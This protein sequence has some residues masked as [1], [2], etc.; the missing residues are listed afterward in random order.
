MKKIELLAPAGSFAALKAAVNAG[1][2]AVYIGGSMFGARAYADNP[3]QDDLIAAIDYCHL[4]G[5]K[6]YLTVNTLFKENELLGMLENY[7]RPYYSAGLDGVI[8][9]D[10]GAMRYISEHF[11]G[12]PIHVSTQAS[13]TAAEGINR[14]MERMPA[15]TRVVPARELSIE[16][17]RNLREHTDAQIEVFIHGALCYSYS[18]QCLLS[19]MIGGRSGNRGRCAQ[20]C[21][22]L[23]DGR[24]LL[25]PKDNCQVFAIDELIEAGVDSF[26]IEGRMKSPEYT[27]G[28]V[29]VYRRLIDLY[30]QY[31]PEGYRRYL[32]E[33]KKMVECEL[34]ELRE[35]YNRGGFNHGY[36][37]Q[38]NGPDMMAFD[39]PN[40]SG[41]Q[42]GEV[43]KTR[44]REAVIRFDRMVNA[45][46]V[47]EIRENQSPV[48]EFTLG[49]GYDSGETFS[50]I[51]MKNRRAEAGMPVYRTRNAELLQTIDT[52]YIEQETKVPVKGC[53]CAHVGDN[54]VLK[55][56]VGGV[57]TM[58]R[59]S[60]PLERATG[61]PMDTA[62]VARQLNKLG[63]TDFIFESLDID[64]DDDVFLV[65]GELNRMRRE[66]IAEL[67]AL[68][69]DTFRRRDDGTQEA[70]YDSECSIGAEAQ[71]RAEGKA[72]AEALFHAE[73]EAEAGIQSHAEGEAEVQTFYDGV[74]VNPK[75]LFSVWKP[76]QLKRLKNIMPDCRVIFNIHSTDITQIEPLLDR[77][78]IIGLPYISRAE[79]LAKVEKF[80]LEIRAKCPGITYMI[81][82]QEEA[83]LLER[84]NMDYIRD[85]NLYAMNSMAAAEY[86]G[87]FTL[88]LE[89]NYDE[90]K[91][92]F[93]GRQDAALIIFGFQPV[94]FSAQCVYR[95][96]FGSCRGRSDFDFTVITDELMHEFRCVQLC[97]FCTNIIYNSARLNLFEHMKEISALDIGTY[98]IDFTFETPEEIEDIVR[99]CHDTSVK[100]TNGHF[101]RGVT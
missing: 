81:R 74:A 18:G 26:K 8:V 11:K 98:R 7:L 63:D 12:L 92:T 91:S 17:I 69:L 44:G 72:D 101:L 40:H 90:I 93:A 30:Y 5:R 41:I 29:S 48:F 70:L 73:G 56:S 9:Q 42:V 45:Q 85:Y 4:R 89:L 3:S 67:K 80:V 31:G 2:D 100:Q 94:M 52:E 59:S 54:A 15:I 20:P 62:T 19:S 57:C 87:D 99:A 97:D 33:H 60:Q 55:L 65:I 25:S 77:N 96:K 37:H 79:T 64:I 27:A 49:Q 1:A 21:R 76:E 82:T 68:F 83:A 36:L 78:L 10:L 39:R 50:C 88:P 61:R 53:F 32:F 47:I 24:Y 6:V 28:V 22:K 14:L 38:Y 46:D 35:L 86:N 16:E 51:T 75:A 58:I 84:L 43:I 66:G 95:N 13:I 34:D 71:S 23:Y